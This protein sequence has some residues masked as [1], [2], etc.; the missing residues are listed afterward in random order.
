MLGEQLVEFTL[1]NQRF[2]QKF[3]VCTLPTEAD[4]LL[5]W[6]FLSTHDLLEDLAKR[7][8]EVQQGATSNLVCGSQSDTV[9][10]FFP[11][12]EGQGGRSAVSSGEKGQGLGQGTNEVLAVPLDFLLDENGQKGQSY[13]LVGEKA[14]SGEQSPREVQDAPVSCL[15][16]AEGQ[17]GRSA[18]GAGVKINGSEQRPKGAQAAPKPVK[19]VSEGWV[20]KLPGTVKLTT[21]AKQMIVGRLEGPVGNEI[22]QL[23]GVEPALLPCTGILVAR[24]DCR[25]VMQMQQLGKARVPRA[26][27]AKATEGRSGKPG[28]SKV[29]VQVMVVNFSHEEVELPKATVLGMA[30]EV[31]ESLV[32]AVNDGTEFEPRK[33]TSKAPIDESFRKYLDDKLG[34]LSEEERSILEPVLVK[35]RNTFYVEGST[36]LKGTDL[37]QHH[38]DTGDA[39]PIRRPPYR[40]PYALREEMDRQVEGMLQKGLIEPSTSRWNFP[41]ILIPKRSID[42]QK[43]FRFCVDFRALN[44]L[45]QHSIYPLPLFDE[46]MST[47]HGSKLLA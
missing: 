7:L 21:R 31:S 12:A 33:N 24:S 6:N 47:L 23:V 39:R 43:R 2:R 22:P 44:Q 19:E 40:V 5:G 37:V 36:V 13:A 35:Y 14:N 4:G 3:G 34:H 45:T 1:G 29:A 27:T 16:A 26:E 11:A 10:T 18:E 42:G 15:T 30:E 9:F 17:E 38:I 41:S 46:T 20:I 28:S 8:R 25:P 32:A